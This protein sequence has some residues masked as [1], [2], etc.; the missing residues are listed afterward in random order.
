MRSTTSREA[1]TLFH[2][3]RREEVSNYLDLR[4][5]LLHRAGDH[6]E[7]DDRLDETLDRPSHDDAHG[8]VGVA[9][10]EVV[11]LRQLARLV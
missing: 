11:E 6:E 5:Q 7:H 9:H 3:H 1:S 8:E 4:Q 10:A 2:I